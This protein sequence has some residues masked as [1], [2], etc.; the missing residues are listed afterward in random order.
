M[1]QA[2]EALEY[3]RAAKC[4]DQIASLRQVFERQRV[5]STRDED[6]DVF[7]LAAEGGEAQVQLFLI[8]RGRL[9]GR[10]TFTFQ[11]A[12]ETAGGLLSALLKQFYLG[13]RDIPREILLSHP[14]EL[15][16]A[17]LIA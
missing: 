15:E 9:V 5:I 10:E 4:R 12:A 1:Q 16:D 7:G 2:A 8:R 11:P 17:P 6:L 13:A 3:E 14:L